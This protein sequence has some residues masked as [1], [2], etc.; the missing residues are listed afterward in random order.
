MLKRRRIPG[1]ATI[2]T[3]FEESLVSLFKARYSF[4]VFWGF[5]LE[6]GDVLNFKLRKR[7]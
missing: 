6:M 5:Y 2:F 1:G 7:K 3:K 4:V